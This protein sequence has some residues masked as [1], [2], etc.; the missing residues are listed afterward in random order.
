M[1]LKQLSIF[2]FKSFAEKVTVDFVPGVTAV[3]GPN[4]SGKSNITDALRWVLGEQS[5]KSLRGG[6]MEDVIFAGSDSRKPL[7]IAE[8]TITLDNESGLL[9]IDYNE[10]SVK[11]CV[12]RTGESEFYINGSRCRLRDIVDLFTD[13]GLGREAFSIISQGKVDQILNS[14][15]EERRTIFE[16]AAGVL[17]Y[18]QRKLKAEGKLTETEDNLNRVNDILHEL[19]GQLETLKAQ[20]EKAKMYLD[21][22]RLKEKSEIALTVYQIETLYQ[23]WESLNSKWEERTESEKSVANAVQQAELALDAERKKQDGLDEAIT[24]LQNIL[25]E[26]SGQLEKLEGTSQVLQERKKNTNG[27]IGQL[28]VSIKEAGRKIEE[29]KNELEATKKLIQEKGQEIKHV[30]VELQDKK[31]E[32]DFFDDQIEATID[33]LK[34]DYVEILNKRA[35][36]NNRLQ[37]LENQL[38]QQEIKLKKTNENYDK[39]T[40]G[41]QEIKNKLLEERERLGQLLQALED[42]AQQEKD[43]VEHMDELKV[44]LDKQQSTLMESYRMADKLKAQK[45][46]LESLAEDYAGYFQGVREVLRAKKS[47]LPGIEGAVAELI[48]VPK[49]LET[50]IEIALGSAVQHVIV[51]SEEDGRKAIEFLKKNKLGRATFLPLNIVRPKQLQSEQISFLRRHSPFIGIASQLIRFDKKYEPAIGNLLGNVI[52]AKDLQGATELAKLLQYRFRI[53]TID[54]E[55]INP[56]GSMTGGNS[57]QKRN[58]LV[59]RKNEIARLKEELH[60]VETAISNHMLEAN[61]L[62]EQLA[63]HNSLLDETAKIKKERQQERQELEKQISQLEIN[64]KNTQ[65]YMALF[66]M[67]KKE[68][69][70]ECSSIKAQM[71]QVS[72]GLESSQKEIAKLDEQIAELT[73]KRN[74]QRQ[75]KELLAGDISELNTR[76]AALNEQINA[77]KANRARLVQ[78]LKESENQMED[79]DKRLS[80]LQEESQ[81]I[82]QNIVDNRQQ[83]NIMREKKEETIQ[84]AAT[85]RK[86]RNEV[87]QSIA[88]IEKELQEL[89][90]KHRQMMNLAKESEMKK[91]RLEIELE[92]Y[93]HILKNDYAMTYDQA[94]AE[95]PLEEP[96]EKTKS[97]LERLKDEIQDMGAVNIGA[98]DEYERVNSRYEF[99]K[100]QQQDLMEAKNTLEQIM[101]EMDGEMIK[102]FGQTFASIQQS[103][104]GV[105]RSLF[106]GGRAKLE[107]TS[108]DD[109]LTTGVEIVAQPPGKKLQ[110]LSLLSGGERSMTAIALL[111]SILKVRPV[112]FCVLDE[113]EAALDEANVHRFSNYLKE[114][115]KNTQ[116]I[117]ITHRQG[118]MAGADVLYGVTMQESGVSKLV[119]VKLEEAEVL[120]K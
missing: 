110:N 77:E 80:A 88:A 19:D 103:F 21:K 35:S 91:N 92:N 120:A 11:R 23:E 5:A 67:E 37:Y 26:V 71:E 75:N 63:R 7:N 49:E 78:T 115:S 101:D 32:L 18:K 58:S 94:K 41:Y 8:V 107:L 48:D 97:R 47:F 1:F 99:L 29:L 17:K 105:F 87:Q 60:A 64:Q 55:V 98:I 46:S 89:K 52:I 39:Y 13:S 27:Q 100:A 53:V 111:F 83:I 16:E 51:Q 109:L 108:P 14:K 50:A 106:G 3:V 85:R 56:G 12:Y 28:H 119:S 40:K 117:V 15:P 69:T 25:L 31:K 76:Y 66:E 34:S 10:V 54:G 6:T 112:P 96:P 20:A 95:Y 82:E 116:F 114:F 104:E 102:R 79:V 45:E 9:P 65:D 2:G 61:K 74:E 70:A 90:R 118:T 84:E 42:I 44:N 68:I 22:K 30:Q 81:N 72:S 57:K 36:E 113:V 86:E 73:N 43:L 38:G 33:S 93:A 24:S 62:K 4:G 59:G